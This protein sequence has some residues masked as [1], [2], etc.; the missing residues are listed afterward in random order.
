MIELI[1]TNMSLKEEILNFLKAKNDW[2]HSGDIEQ[3][4]F[5]LGY[6]ADNG[7]RRCRE[8]SNS[9]LIEKEL[10]NGSVWYR[11]GESQIVKE[12]REIRERAE[13]KK[14]KND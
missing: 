11:C 7:G 1:I 10:R 8:L 2:V 12:L 5:S 6:K 4:S 9:G 14:K 13:M 3:L